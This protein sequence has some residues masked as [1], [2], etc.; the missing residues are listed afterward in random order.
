M[1][2]WAP[3]LAGDGDVC[4]RKLR[5]FTIALSDALRAQIELQSVQNRSFMHVWASSLLRCLR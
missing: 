3:T 2:F 4:D 1:T 5:R